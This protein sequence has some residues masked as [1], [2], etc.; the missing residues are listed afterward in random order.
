MVIE[1]EAAMDEIFISVQTDPDDLGTWVEVGSCR[2]S[3]N[4]DD[5]TACDLARNIVHEADWI[6]GT[7]NLVVIREDDHGIRVLYEGL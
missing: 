1:Q 3:R 6:I 7:V 2:I 4:A 5:E